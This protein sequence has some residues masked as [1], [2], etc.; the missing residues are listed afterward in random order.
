MDSM[1]A[2]LLI[3][4]NYALQ[5]FRVNLALMTLINTQ[6]LFPWC[7]L[8]CDRCPKVITSETVIK[9]F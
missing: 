2:D 4:N 9:N 5:F 6:A 3:F 1:H 8:N 7:L